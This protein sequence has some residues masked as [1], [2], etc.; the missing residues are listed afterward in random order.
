M[1]LAHVS[2]ALAAILGG[3]AVV[4][5]SAWDFDPMAPRARTALAPEDYAAL[6]GRVAQLQA[7]RG[8]IQAR[9]AVERDVW[10][11]QRDYADL[12]RVG[13]TLSPLERQLADAVPAR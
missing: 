9:I 8:G 6:S 13:R 4:P 10:K 5:H 1:R 3:C 2:F 7:D 11:R 12:H